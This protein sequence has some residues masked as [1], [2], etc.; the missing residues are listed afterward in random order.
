MKFK[1][2]LKEA[3]KILEPIF[4]ANNAQ[5]F[6]NDLKNK[7]KVPYS[8]VQVSMLGG[9]ENVSV[10]FRVSLEPQE[11]WDY[12][13][14]HNSR[15]SFF[16]ISRYGKIEQFGKSYEISKKFR[17]ATAKSTKDAIDKI[18]KYLKQIK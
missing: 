13:I 2:Y 16:S 10:L 9:A 1:E 14:L 8:D 11:E 12:G 3:K 18:S 5:K 6:A 4:D 7:I 17:K 15:Y